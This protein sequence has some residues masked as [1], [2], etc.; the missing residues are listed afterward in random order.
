L[1]IKLF[2]FA[3]ISRD[4]ALCYRFFRK[5]G[6]SNDSRRFSNQSVQSKVFA[7][8]GKRR[9]ADVLLAKQLSDNPS[10]GPLPALF[11]PINSNIY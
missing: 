10:N 2:F 4:H 1:L 9:R 6:D 7:H 11:G 8:A 5:A 3:D